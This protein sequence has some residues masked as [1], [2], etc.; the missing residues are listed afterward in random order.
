[1]NLP[2]F[3]W[4]WS[5]EGGRLLCPVKDDERVVHKSEELRLMWAHQGLGEYPHRDEPIWTDSLSPCSP[6]IHR[7]KGDGIWP[8]MA[9]YARMVVP[10]RVET[11]PA[12]WLVNHRFSSWPNMT[13]VPKTHFYNQNWRGEKE[14]VDY[15]YWKCPDMELDDYGRRNGRKWS[16]NLRKSSIKA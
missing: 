11:F 9:P 1:M 10:V 5:K 16:K 7:W 3:S 8:Q 15:H 2:P 4:N 12:T 14:L 13:W 6:Q